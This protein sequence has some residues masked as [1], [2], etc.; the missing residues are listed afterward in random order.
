MNYEELRAQLEADREW[1][2]AEIR[3]FQN[4]GS[5]LATKTEQDRHRRLLILILYSH[6]EGF[7]KFA[8]TL[9]INAINSENVQIAD[10]NYAIAALAMSD[11]LKALANPDSKC[12]AFRNALPDDAKLHRFGRQQEFLQRFDEFRSKPVVIPE[13]AIDLESNLKP[14]VLRKCLFQIGL[15]HDQFEPIEG[16]ITQ[17]L[18]SRNDI[19]HGSSRSGIDQSTYTR[20]RQCAFKVMAVVLSQISQALASKAFERKAPI[21]LPEPA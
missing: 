20:V 7:C 6:Y 14:A 8:F 4:Q 13:D 2:E 15:R 3:R 16:E 9:Y 1:R 5:S 17:L 19:A 21:L 10:A 11:I 12:V 18:K